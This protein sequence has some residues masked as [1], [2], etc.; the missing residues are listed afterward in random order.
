MTGSNEA[1]LEGL[2]KSMPRRQSRFFWTTIALAIVVML[3]LCTFLTLIAAS[4]S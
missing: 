2:P 1:P 3:L 4:R